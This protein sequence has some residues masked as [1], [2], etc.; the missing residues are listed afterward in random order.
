MEVPRDRL[1][2]TDEFGDRVYIYPA[3]ARGYWRTRR[4][5][6]QYT[7]IVLF[8]ILPWLKINGSQAVLLSISKREFALFGLTFFA[9]DGPLIFFVLAILTLSLA[10]ITAIWGRIWCGWVCP[11]TVFIDGVFR[12]IEKIVEGDHLQRRKLDQESLSF[13][14]VFKKVLKWFL[15]FGVSTA[16]A[17]SFIAYFTGAEE[18]LR[19]ISHPPAENWTDF[20]IVFFISGMLLFNFGWFKEQ[21]CIIM[22]PYG[23]FQSILMDNNSL[24]VLYDEKRGEPRKRPDLPKEKQGDCVNC[25]RCVMVCP[26]GIDIRRGVQMECINCTA[27]IDACDEI[28]QKVHKPK[29]LIRYSSTVEMLEN[30]KSLFWNFR[31]GLYLLLI[32]L[33]FIVLTFKVSTREN[34]HMELLRVKGAPYRILE[35]LEQGFVINQFNAHIRN[36][37]NAPLTVKFNINNANR[38]DS[39]VFAAVQLIQQSPEIKVQVGEIRNHLLFVKFPSALTAELGQAN[40][41]IQVYYQATDIEMQQGS[42][43]S[44]MKL[45]GPLK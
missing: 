12:K 9:N 15:F 10:L 24:S 20:L 29:G 25:G 8:L 13:K 2:T 7:L 36:Q 30:K 27:C 1:A 28:M 42:V 22:C 5:W 44:E 35:G 37:T 43:E 14:K 18:L 16:I 26:T 3:E 19:M 38:I 41:K 39:N 17:H 34:L 40:I 4:T 31:T 32:L 45:L 23:R 6:T 33:S 11:Q 21:F